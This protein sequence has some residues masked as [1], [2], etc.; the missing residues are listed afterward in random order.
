MKRTGQGMFIYDDE[1]R[2]RYGDKADAIIVAL[3]ADHATQKDMAT[4]PKGARS[5]VNVEKFLAA[6]PKDE[7][8]ADESQ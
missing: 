1:I 6:I 2:D 3:D 5:K 4:W 8:T 7:P